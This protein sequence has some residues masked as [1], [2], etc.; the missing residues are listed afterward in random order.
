MQ[1]LCN[2]LSVSFFVGLFLLFF[3]E[4]LFVQILGRETPEWLK[5]LREN[6]LMTFFLLMFLNVMSSKLM[7]TGA[8]E[9]SLDEKPIWSAIERGGVLQF[10]DLLIM[11]KQNGLPPTN[12]KLE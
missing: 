4:T 6:K 1:I 8:F 7:A 11:L 10:R 2:I 5:Y 3:G 9:I 12:L